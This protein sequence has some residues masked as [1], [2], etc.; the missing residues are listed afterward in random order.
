MTYL[1][2]EEQTMPIELQLGQYSLGLQ[3][4]KTK[5]DAIELLKE[6]YEK[7][8]TNQIEKTEVLIDGIFH[9]LNNPNSHNLIRVT[10]VAVELKRLKEL[11][12]K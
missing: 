3:S 5:G 8:K 12:R 6:I 4:C 2:D 7:G 10:S 9:K 1:T 11:I